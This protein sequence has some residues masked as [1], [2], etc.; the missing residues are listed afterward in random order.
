M[1]SVP[2]AAL[3]AILLAPFAASGCSDQHDASHAQHTSPHRHGEVHG[4]EHSDEHGDKHSDGHGDKHRDEHGARRVVRVSQAAI[5]RSGIRVA[6]VLAVPAAGGIEVPAEIQA[7]P[8]RLAHVSSVVSGQIARVSAA[9]GDRV[10]PGQTLAVIRSVA[11]GQARAQ[12]ARA[13]ADI[14]VAQSNFRRQQELKREGIGAERHFLEAQA[15]LRRAQA[16]QSAAEQALEVYGRGGQ[17]S[18]ITIKSPIAGRVIARHATVGEVVDPSD[19]LFEIT[20]ITRVWAVGRV[21]QQNAGQVREGASAVLTL[22]AHPGRSF[23]GNLD[24]VAPALDERTRT[25]PVRVNLDNPDGTLRPG[26]FGT[27]SISP[28]DVADETVAAVAVSAV[29]RL[30]DDTIVFVP[31]AEA[32]EFRA[33]PVVTETYSGELVRVKLGLSAGDRYVVDGAFVLKSELSRGE[34]G[35]GHAH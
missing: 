34:L 3:V 27:L 26:L 8:D 17:G 22:Q 25:L 15:A 11:L 7:E 4:D 5:E 21:Y 19:T 31:G 14:E 1:K 23:S 24:Y 35:A 29:Q 18:E 10:K 9:V 32:G 6:E 33:V 28:S 13:R 12:A 30:G 16:E 2:A 20:D